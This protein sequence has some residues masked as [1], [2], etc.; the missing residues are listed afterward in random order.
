[1]INLPRECYVGKF[2]PKKTFYER[3]KIATN[4]K[5]EFVDKIEKITWLYK[6]SEDTLG[7]LKTEDVEEI[8]VFEIELKEKDIPKG[9]ISLIAKVIQYPIL[10]VLKYNDELLYAIKYENIFYTEWNEEVNIK[11]QGIN[12]QIVSE[13]II[14]SIIREEE[15][16]ENIADIVK[17]NAILLEYEKQIEAIE[18]QI[19]NEK[20]FN[21]KVELNQRLQKLKKEMEEYKNG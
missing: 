11:W 5:D 4:I 16:E 15:N 10:F 21:R 8:Q 18:R 9:A 1:M 17:S 6:V 19:N 7:I 14:K 13:N 12:L 3:A 2:I 20:Q